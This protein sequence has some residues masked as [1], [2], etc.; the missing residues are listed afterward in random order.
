MVAG[1]VISE[2]Q[3]RRACGTKDSDIVER[4]VLAIVAPIHTH[5]AFLYKGTSLQKE[6]IF[7]E[8]KA[9]NY[10]AHKVGMT[11]DV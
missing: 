9:P 1:I 10:K 8:Q 2:R 4:S 5:R 6:R 7:E 3:P 11:T